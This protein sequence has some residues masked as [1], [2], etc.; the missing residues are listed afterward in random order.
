MAEVIDVPGPSPKLFEELRALE[1]L[2]LRPEDKSWMEKPL[3]QPKT[4]K[5]LL[6]LGCNILR[7][8]HLARTVVDIFHK[9]GEDFEALAGPAFCCGVPYEKIEGIDG[10]RLRGMSLASRFQQFKPQQVVF[11]CPGCLDF[12]KNILAIAASFRL[13][14]VSEFLA[15][16]RSKL[17]L[18]PLPPTRVALHYHC[19]TADS[20]Q[21]A[22]STKAVLTAVPGLELVDIGSTPE[23]GRQCT[24]IL[25]QRMGQ[26]AWVAAIKPFFHR[27]VELGADIFATPY[28][29]CHRT[30]VSYE[31][32][33]PFSIEHYLSIVGRAL[34]IS[35]PDKYKQYLLWKDQNRILEDA[36]PC[37]EANRVSP[38][39]ARIVVDRVFLKEEGL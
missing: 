28:H 9:L 34:G 30:Y 16:N 6:Y 22:I 19:G 3:G 10:A 21:Q 5:T 18:T 32:Q 13:I 39:L 29:G 8:P 7:T 1:G 20:E 14:H 35:Y 25:R 31:K 26:E 38:E 27:A 36:S 17:S 23:W 12:Y 15:E 4:A 24:G 11:W 2:L 37:L 33:F